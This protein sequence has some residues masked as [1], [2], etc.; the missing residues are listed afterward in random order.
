[1]FVLST[2][3]VPIRAAVVSCILFLAGLSTGFAQ[4]EPTPVP[5]SIPE[6]PSLAVQGDPTDDVEATFIDEDFATVALLEQGSVNVI[7]E[8]HD[9]PA[10]IILDQV[11]AVEG[12]TIGLAKGKERVE[13][14]KDAQNDVSN[15][16]KEKQVKGNEIYRMQRAF[17]G[18]AM[19]VD[20]ADL[21][22]IA[23]MPEVKSV[24]PIVEHYPDAASSNPLMRVESFWA[25]LPAGLNMRGTGVKVGVIDSGVDY[26]H[27]AFGGPGITGAAA[28]VTDTNANGHFPNAKFPGGW[29]FVGN[30]YTGSAT[31]PQP[32]ANPWEGV[33]GHG[34]AV[35]SLIGGRG[36]NGDGTTYTG[37]YNSATNYAAMRTS[38]GVAPDA[39]IYP[40][41]VFGNSGSTALTHLAIEWAMDPDGDGDM[42]DRLDVINLSLGAANGHPDDL[43]ARTADAATK[44]GIV[45]VISAG[46]SYN[47]Y[48]ITGSPSVGDGTLSV[49]ASLNDQFFQT[50]KVTSPASIAKDYLMV[51]ASFGP[52]FPIAGLSSNLVVANPIR[53]TGSVGGTVPLLNAADCAGKIVIMERGA[54]PAPWGTSAAFVDKVRNAQNAGAIGVIVLNNAAGSATTMGGADPLVTIPSAMISQADGVIITGAIATQTVAANASSKGNIGGSDTMAIYSSRGPRRG[55]SMLKPDITAP[56]ELVSAALVNTGNG[57]RTFNG[58]SSAAPHMAGGMA[59][60]RQANPTWNQDEL[61]ALAMNTAKFDLFNDNFFTPP[62][63]SS[64]RVGAGRVDLEGAARSKVIAFNKDRPDLVSVSYGQVEAAETLNLVRHISVRN[65]SNAKVSYKIS[66]V[67]LMELPGVSIDLDSRK[68][69][70]PPA[71][72]T[73]H[74]PIKLRIDPS[75]MK[76]V[77]DPLIPALQNLNPGGLQPR[78]FLNEFA[79]H[80]VLTPTSGNAPVLRVPVWA[81]VRPA[82]QMSAAGATVTMNAPTGIANVPVAG[83][84][85]NTAGTATPAFPNDLIGLVKGYELQHETK[86]EDAVYTGYLSGA[87]IQY[88]GVSSDFRTRG[89]NWAT[90]VLNFG[91]SM[92]GNWDTPSIHGVETQI[93]I[94][95]NNDGVADFTVFTRSPT[96]LD[97]GTAASPS[98]V[99]VTYFTKHFAPGAGTFLFA[100]RPVNGLAPTSINTYALNNSVVSIDIPAGNVGVTAA[101][102]NF[103]Y[104]VRGLWRGVL[105]SQTGWLAYNPST[106][107]LDTAGTA[108]LEP[109]WYFDTNGNTVPVRWNAANYTARGSKGLLLLHPHNTAGSRAEKVSVVIP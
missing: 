43:T 34:T 88:A 96:D 32:D 91:V 38:P 71:G 26:L 36:T 49:A 14:I 107:G 66:W 53:G 23:A 56:A 94:D 86:P 42:S 105:V 15:K 3:L 20:P 102:P 83:V 95:N 30:N 33:N 16:M 76:N 67:P 48:Y 31:V 2:R 8:L 35:A 6:A 25:A 109:F 100:T 37:T 13:K 90:T 92:F 75:Q 106:P 65:K 80:I 74:F 18:I 51:P 62:K 12:R 29:D 50:F 55:D 52:A 63:W 19:R 5:E 73:N 58:T 98:N 82:A 79:G 28:G 46:N 27:A 57:N 99:Y 81:A 72:S 1:M 103:R 87:E 40:L 108:N 17:N 77:R 64:T 47:V 61:K 59:L 10:A 78:H 97:T 70:S 85:L 7:V 68:D 21:A 60:M 9:A 41:R 69:I 54:P 84:E 44:A 45:V 11:T 104:R 89:N 101:A 93:Q 4:T 22:A 39:L 24:M